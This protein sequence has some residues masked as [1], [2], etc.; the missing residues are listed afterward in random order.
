MKDRIP[1]I[2]K[3]RNLFFEGRGRSD[4]CCVFGDFPS[5]CAINLILT[6]DFL[7]DG[8]DDDDDI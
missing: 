5:V 6:R 7:S 4:F 1:I 2:K 3:L 8:D